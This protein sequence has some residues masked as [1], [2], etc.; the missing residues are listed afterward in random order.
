MKKYTKIFLLFSI[1]FLIGVAIA[2][3]LNL[4]TD[5]KYKSALEFF[6]LG[7]VLSY[8]CYRFEFFVN[9]FHFG[10]RLRRFSDIDFLMFF[11]IVS[12]FVGNQYEFK[13]YLIYYLC[14]FGIGLIFIVTSIFEPVV[15]DA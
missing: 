9:S 8:V 4:K 12:L 3:I 6:L 10:L 13:N 15:S 2:Y 5:G 11:G 7:T 14:K 1:S